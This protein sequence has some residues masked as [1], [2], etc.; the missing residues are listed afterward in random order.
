MR[1]STDLDALDSLPRR[2]PVGR[3]VIDDDEA[4]ELARERRR[5]SEDCWGEDYYADCDESCA[6][7]GLPAVDGGRVR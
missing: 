1:P 7:E 2:A 6:A 3:T 4:A 5:W